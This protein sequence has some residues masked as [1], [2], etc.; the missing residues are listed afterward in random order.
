MKLVLRYLALKSSDQKW[1]PQ[2]QN[3]LPHPCLLGGLQVGGN[4]T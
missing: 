3:W 2:N 4:A 1:L